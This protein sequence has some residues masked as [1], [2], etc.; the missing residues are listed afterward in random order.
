MFYLNPNDLNFEGLKEA[1]LIFSTEDKLLAVLL[2]LPKNKFNSIYES[3]NSKYKL[4]KKEI[5]FVGDKEAKFLDGNT[6]VTLNA[7]HMSFDMDLHYINKDLW[8]VYKKIQQK[9]QEEKS[10]KESSQL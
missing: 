7:P 4:L 2:K 6:E 9:E 3:L 5:P 8:K 10:K 1:M